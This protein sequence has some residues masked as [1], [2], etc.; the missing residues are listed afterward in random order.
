[1]VVVV[2]QKRQPQGTS[3][4]PISVWITFAAVP[5]A[6]VCHM[7]M[8]S[9][10]VEGGLCRAVATEGHDS[11]EAIGSMICRNPNTKRLLHPPCARRFARNLRTVVSKADVVSALIYTFGREVVVS[12]DKRAESYS[13][14]FRL[15]WKLTTGKTIKKPSQKRHPWETGLN[16]DWKNKL[17]FSYISSGGGVGAAGGK[18]EGR[19][20]FHREVKT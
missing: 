8:P 2:F 6:K 1:M 11:L 3:S 10:T 9:I 7:A 4:Y 12:N 15:L 16:W 13:Q 18:E 20:A 14:T 17:A 19:K 5:L